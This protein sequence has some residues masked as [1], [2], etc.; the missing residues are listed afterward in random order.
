MP[1]RLGGH[2]LQPT[3]TIFKLI[4]DIILTYLLTKF[5]EDQTKNVASRVL[6]GK[7]CPTS[8]WSFFRATGTIFEFFHDEWKINVVSRVLT[9]KYA[10]PPGGHVFQPTKIIFELFQ[11]IIPLNFLTKFIQ[12]WTINPYYKNALPFSSHV[13]LAN[14]TILN[15]SKISLRPI[16]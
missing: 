9:R 5:Y 15:S 14:V 12:D 6:T 16:F 3:R 7:K 8:W 11:D 2:V 4:Q 13:F 10:P 1:L